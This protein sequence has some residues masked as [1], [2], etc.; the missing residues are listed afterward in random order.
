VRFKAVLPIGRGVDLDLA[1]ADYNSL[2]DSVET[3]AASPG[4]NATC[5]LGMNLYIDPHGHCFPC[6]ALMGNTHSLGNAL[7]DGLVEVL[8]KNN[9]YR[10]ATV[11]S[12][13]KCHDC[14]LRYLCGGF[15]RAWS[16]NG[17]PDSAPVD[18]SA[19]QIKAQERL[20]G[21]L[22][23]LNTTPVDWQKAGL[24]MPTGMV[25]YKKDHQKKGW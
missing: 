19:L 10:K 1:P 15:C 20:L 14:V 4:S 25:F 18:C 8:E 9:R 3:L 7:E 21:A 5:G 16:K 24:T 2:D 11:D 22:E 13:V 6:Y 17:S 12:N 23:T